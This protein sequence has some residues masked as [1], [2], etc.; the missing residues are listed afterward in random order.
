MLSL[1]QEFLTEH[2]L[3]NKT[4]QNLKILRGDYLNANFKN[5]QICLV[6]L[7]IK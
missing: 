3:S 4:P 6:F 2:F 5:Y 1:T 7:N